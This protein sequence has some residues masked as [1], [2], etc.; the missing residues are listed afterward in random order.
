MTESYSFL[1]GLRELRVTL[2]E[3]RLEKLRVG[4]DGRNRVMLS[5]FG[6]SSG[7]NTPPSTGFIFGPSTWL[8][9][10][11]KPAEGRALAYIDWSSQEVWIAA[12]LSN[13]P[14]MLAAVESG[15]PYLSFA[16]QAGLA[17]AD[18]TKQSHA[19]I[20]S[21]CKAVVL[22]V[23]YGMQARTLASRTGLSVVEAQN[24][25]TRME[26]TFPVYTEWVQQVIGA[27]IMR[28]SLSTCFGWT[29]LTASDRS[30]T[31]RNWPI[32]SAGAEMLRLASNLIVEQG[33]T[34]DAP[35]H[36]AVAVE[37]PVDAIDEAVDI[38][39]DCMATASATLLDGL[40]IGTDAAVV[41]WPGRYFDPRGI[42]M[43]DK[44]TGIIDRLEWQS[45]CRA[46]GGD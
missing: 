3:L 40:V 11:I 42:A 19:D 44:V 6:A 4:P 35:I 36:D 28:G 9:S 20:R 13:D 21:R 18:A 26:R 12:Y 2:S 14:A 27:G 8:R 24:L 29:R 22:G 31:I 37:A 43:W 17:P 16:V 5:P 33:I 23:N 32:Q 45:D 46:H 25:I 34:L 39:R 30:T 41:T 15:D 38:T 1:R 10:L 7:R